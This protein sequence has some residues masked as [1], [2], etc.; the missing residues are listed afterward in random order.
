MGSRGDG[1][2]WPPDGG[3]PDL[4]P[5]WGDIVIPDDLSALADEAAAVR[6]ELRRNERHTP[7]QRF[8]ARPGIRTVSRILSAGLRLPVLIISIAV[9][10]TGASLFASAWQGPARP[11]AT[12]R[13]GGTYADSPGSLPAL[14]VPGID[15]RLVSLRQQLPTVVLLIEGCSCTTLIEETAAAVPPP[16]SVVTISHGYPPK[17]PSPTPGAVGPTNPTPAEPGVGVPTALPAFGPVHALWDPSDELRKTFFDNV[18]PDGTAAALLVDRRGRIVRKIPRT[19]SVR[20]IRPDLA[21][22]T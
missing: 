13:T 22:L 16:V 21:R 7:W 17:L 20:D 11:P 10:V 9:L 1:G 12:Q 15:G 19:N 14:E 8:G 4:P 2:G 3:V 18:E 6:A 5:E